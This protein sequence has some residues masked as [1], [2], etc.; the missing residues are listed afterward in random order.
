MTDMLTA[1]N[2]LAHVNKVFRVKE[3][4]HALTLSQV[5]LRRMD[6]RELAALGR[7]S[8]TLIFAGPPDNV[9][10]GG[11]YT[12]DVEGGP[13]FQLYVIPIRTFAR[14]RQDYQAVFN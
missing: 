9:L 2:F 7:Q 10:R 1:E 6:E 5:E 8:F 13:T 12:L 3:S 4:G 14:D 11:L